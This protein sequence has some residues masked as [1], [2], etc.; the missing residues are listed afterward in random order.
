MAEK[1][2][3]K[4]TVNDLVTDPAQKRKKKIVVS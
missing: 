2:I 4:H 1:A 3:W